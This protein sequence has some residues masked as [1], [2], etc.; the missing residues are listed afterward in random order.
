MDTELNPKKTYALVVGIEKYSNVSEEYW[1]DGPARNAVDFA[2]WL[3]DKEVSPDNIGLFISPLDDNYSFIK[4]ADL[5]DINNEATSTN[6]NKYIE[7]KIYNQ[8]NKGHLLYV[9]WGSHGETNTTGERLE[10]ILLYSDYSEDSPKHLSFDLLHNALKRPLSGQ[11]FQK[12]I[13]IID[14]CRN[15]YDLQQ[16]YETYRVNFKP[17][18]KDNIKEQFILYATLQGD[19]AQNKQGTGIF[20]SEVLKALN[21]YL[22]MPDMDELAGKIKDNLEPN[23]QKISVD[24]TDWFEDKYPLFRINKGEKTK[25]DWRDAPAVNFFFGRDQ[26]LNT[27]EK[28]I[29]EDNCRLVAIVGMG[30]IGKTDLS[31]SLNFCDGG[32]G[33]TD[34]SLTLAKKIQNK[35]EYIIWKSLKF[36]PPVED[37]LEVLLEPLS[38][39]KR[40]QLPDKFE[41]KISLLVESLQAKRCLLILDNAESILKGGNRAGQYREGYEG[42][43]ELFRQV[44]QRYHQSCLLITSRETPK[45]ISQLEGA[46][47]PVRFF[48]LSGLEESAAREIFN[49]IGSFSG[50]EEEWQRII[51]FYDGNPLALEIVAKYIYHQLA[52]N[53]SNFI[54][55]RTPIFG[56]LQELLDWHFDR[57]SSYEK[58]LMYWL[59]INQEPVSNL[60]LKEDILSNKSKKNLPN[61]LQSLEQ[62]LP[63]K[64]SDT[65]A[66]ITLQPVLIEY[67][68]DRLVDEIVNEIKTFGE[69]RVEKNSLLNSHALLK[70]QALDYIRETQKRLIVKP[71]ID[72]LEDESEVCIDAQ[73][74]KIL[75]ELPRKTRKPQPSYISGNILNLLCELDNYNKISDYDFSK[76]EIRQ[77]YLPGKTLAK[78]KF[79]NC[80]FISTEFTIPFARILSIALNKNGDIFATGDSKGDVRLWQT[81]DGK[82]MFVSI[83]GHK[84]WVSSVSF[85]SKNNLLAS[86]S[87]DKSIVFWDLQN[88]E[89]LAE[90]ENNYIDIKKLEIIDD[91]HTK[92]IRSITFSPDSQT[93]ASSSDDS[94]IKLWKIQFQESKFTIELDGILPKD[95]RGKINSV[96]FSPDGKTLAS[97]SDDNT[98]KI[99]DVQSRQLIETLDKHTNYVNSVAFSPDGRTLASA[100]ND[101]SV[102]LW[103]FDSQTQSIAY[104]DSLPHNDCVTSIV[105]C[106][107]SKTIA[108]G[109]LDS[110]IIIWNLEK[111]SIS[112]RFQHGRGGLCLAGNKDKPFLIS[113][114]YNNSIKI[115]DLREEKCL[116]TLQGY[117]DSVRSVDFS[118]DGKHLAVG[119]VDSKVRI[120]DTYKKRFIEELDEHSEGIRVVT[121]SPNGKVLASG[122][123][124]GTVK[125]WSYPKYEI[126]GDISGLN[127]VKIWSISFSIDAKKLAIG[128]GE[129][130]IQ[131][132]DCEKKKTITHFSGHK[133]IIYSVAF[134]PNP[135]FPIIASASHDETLKIWDLE[136]FNCLQVLKEHNSWINSVTFSRDGKTLISASD[137]KT[138][139]FWDFDDQTKKWKSN[140]LTLQH[141]GGVRQI[142]I[143]PDNTTLASASDD[144]TVRIWNL[145]TGCQIGENLV[146]NE[147]WVWSVAYGHNSS[148]NSVLLASGGE[149]STIRIWDL[150]TN[151]PHDKFEIPKPYQEVSIS[152]VTGLNNTQIATLKVLGAE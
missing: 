69:T 142:S 12:Q 104:I 108:T 6:I 62:R 31:L 79:N 26:E 40:F 68:I 91:A 100:S 16:G 44:G 1:L 8:G 116:K 151:N 53:L 33:K 42:Y 19:V 96:A 126:V 109:S 43:G 58:E 131:L 95:H 136:N 10:Q 61:T 30:G 128:N 7:D 38:N 15:Y 106:P 48:P 47:L 83:R 144:K 25:Q 145:K 102:I 9:F 32:I 82:E 11:G 89:N 127:G 13:Y 85:S 22:L 139:R 87:E 119:T 28:W 123:R 107:D 114:C 41:D 121:Y 138:I 63:I 133:G 84:S 148:N 3:L 73:F 18:N 24:C 2:K 5:I 56:D 110:N 52:G 112:K 37:I 71:I 115:L 20:S 36:A 111:R 132:W 101:K 70:A 113:G 81:K 78:I 17:K 60:E 51:K 94:S 64:K 75:A 125:L 122:S 150:N 88:L 118:L 120:F 54:E 143:S 27:L 124:D 67:M 137:D 45:E 86:A 93:L 57:F 140:R 4:K 74:K 55:E 97:A 46:K 146:G 117:N 59:A 90:K 141:D 149:D 72:K 99:W 80:H 34:L 39:Q 103:G 76:L 66:R 23:K 35:F 49:I 14:A 29:I 98:V 129:G 147:G 152:G 21:S 105:F 77:A 130:K 65:D 92:R 50:S 135:H 134:N